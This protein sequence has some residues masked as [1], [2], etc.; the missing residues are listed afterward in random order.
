MTCFGQ[1]DKKHVSTHSIE[2]NTQ[3]KIKT[4]VADHYDANASEKENW[5]GIEIVDENLNAKENQNKINIKVK[6]KWHVVIATI[7][8]QYGGHFSAENSQRSEKCNIWFLFYYD[9][10]QGKFR[11]EIETGIWILLLVKE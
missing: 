11:I 5:N 2:I 6:I 10:T 7:S 3:I 4:E 9:L 1:D 8:F